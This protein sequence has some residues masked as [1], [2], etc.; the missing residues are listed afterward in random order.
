M[1]DDLL[2]VRYLDETCWAG[3]C[4]H[5]TQYVIISIGTI[6]GETYRTLAG[7]CRRDAEHFSFWLPY[8]YDV[9]IESVVDYDPKEHG[10]E[11]LPS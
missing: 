3:G 8:N 6:G 7:Y 9:T 5:P 10:N 4:K 1:S 11:A 2:E